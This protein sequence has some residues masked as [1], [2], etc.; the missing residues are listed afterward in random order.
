MS[1][2][3]LV[4]GGSA[5]IGAATCRLAPARGWERVVVHYGRDREAAE[6][7]AE[8]VRAEGAEA[9]VLGADVADPAQVVELFAE[10][11]ALAP[12]PLDLVNNAGIVAP[13]GALADLTPERVRRVFEVNVFGAIEVARQ[14]V[15]YM[16][17][18]AGGGIVNVSSVAARLGSARQYMDYA[19][20]KGAIDTFTLGLADELAAE[21]VR[22]NAVRPGLIETGIHAKGGEPDRLARIG[23]TPPLGRAG[24]AE[25]VAESILWLLS[26]RAGYVTRSI[27][28][29]GGGR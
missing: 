9:H 28:D 10:L 18:H 17:A 14:A 12:G 23:H 3:L 21:G 20:S 11:T 16:R 5:G 22:V 7:V 15:A 6:A 25:E 19:A 24:T 13:T 26:D 1:R 29:V 27:L 8:E 2:L 4:T